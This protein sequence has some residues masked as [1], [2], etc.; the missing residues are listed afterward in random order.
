M[1]DR[2]DLK[3]EVIQSKYANDPDFGDLLGD[4]AEGLDERINQMQKALEQGDFGQVTDL[5]HKL[6]GAAGFTGY[7]TL[8]E[9]AKTL[10]HTAAKSSDVNATTLA[11]NDLNSIC[12]A[13]VRGVNQ[14]HKEK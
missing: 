4:F 14:L 10:E 8:S 6:K 9:T 5:A 13:V 3:A 1:T 7:P 2:N 11:L 12:R